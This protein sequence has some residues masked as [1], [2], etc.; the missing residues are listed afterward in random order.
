MKFSRLFFQP[1]DSNL[2][3][4]FRQ[5]YTVASL[6]SEL[7]NKLAK[8]TLCT[9]GVSIKRHHMIKSPRVSI[10]GING[11]GAVSFPVPGILKKAIAISWSSLPLVCL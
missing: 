9:L 10:F 6:P 7:L 3:I 11:E 4:A 2:T 8:Y 5:H 1:K